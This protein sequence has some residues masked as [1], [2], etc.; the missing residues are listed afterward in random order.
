MFVDLRWPEFFGSSIVFMA[1]SQ[2][3]S[4]EILAKLEGIIHRYIY[5]ANVLVVGRAPKNVI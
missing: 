3:E 4:S 2:V 1:P 5:Q